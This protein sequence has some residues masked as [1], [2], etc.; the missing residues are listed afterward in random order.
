V[1]ESLRIL[2]PVFAS[3]PDAGVEA[4]VQL[5]TK[6]AYAEGHNI[7]QLKHVWE[8]ITRFPAIFYPY[9]EQL[10]TLIKYTYENYAAVEIKLIVNVMHLEILWG[11]QCVLGLAHDGQ[12]TGGAAAVRDN[13]TEGCSRALNRNSQSGIDTTPGPRRPSGGEGGVVGGGG[14]GSCGGGGGGSGGGASGG[15]DGSCGSSTNGHING[16]GATSSGDSMPVR[17]AEY[18]RPCKRGAPTPYP[19]LR[20]H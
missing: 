10:Y 2:M 6:V 14:D 17:D 9:R 8:C 5:T 19:V 13:G 16:D 12:K 11:K 3:R 7:E 18:P 15:G 20:R 4:A 1:F